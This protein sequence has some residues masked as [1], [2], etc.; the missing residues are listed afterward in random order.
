[1]YAMGTMIT[2]VDKQHCRQY[3]MASLERKG[4]KLGYELSMQWQGV[5]KGV[6]EVTVL[7]YD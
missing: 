5:Q 1:M 7:A 3:S 6:V 4:N 2:N